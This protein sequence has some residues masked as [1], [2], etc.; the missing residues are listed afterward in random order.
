MQFPLLENISDVL[1]L[2]GFVN[3]THPFGF[4]LSVISEGKP[5]LGFLKL[6]YFHK[7]YTRVYLMVVVIVQSLSHVWLFATPWLQ[8]VRPPCP[9]VSPRVCSNP[10]PLSRCCH[11]AILSFV[12]P[13]SSCLQSF[14]AS[15]SLLIS[16]NFTSDGQSIGAS[17]SVLSMNI[18]DWIPLG[19][20]VLISLQSKGLSSVFSN[21]TVQNYQF[22]SPQPSL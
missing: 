1:F 6:S 15:G 9:S 11:S 18:Q 21:T 22:F 16:W 13:F 10:C 4:G 8:H 7:I 3:S 2:L 14:S 12:V 19:L 17:A 20:S 5:S